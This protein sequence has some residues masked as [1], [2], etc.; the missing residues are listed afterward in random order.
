MTQAEQ[1]LHEINTGKKS[2]R[3]MPTLAEIMEGA[4][5]ADNF[6]G[7]K[8]GKAKKAVRV[9]QRQEK[10]SVKIDA[11][12]GRTENKRSKAQ[13]RVILAEQGIIQTNTGGEILSGAK[14]LISGLTGGGAKQESTEQKLQESTSPPVEA[15][16]GTNIEERQQPTENVTAAEKGLEPKK[17]NKILLIG[18][19]ALALFLIMKNK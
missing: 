19:A 12:R 4:E 16:V 15:G 8:K 3:R 13:S 10:R 9:Q 11:R 5:G 2:V 1:T 18:G 6:L 14:T 7:G 17:D